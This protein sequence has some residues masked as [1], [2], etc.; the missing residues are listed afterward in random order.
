MELDPSDAEPYFEVGKILAAQGE[1]TEA[2]DCLE[3]HIFLGGRKEKEAKELLSQIK[4]IIFF[5]VRGR[6]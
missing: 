2:A 6:S 5:P 1:F 3:K 4:K